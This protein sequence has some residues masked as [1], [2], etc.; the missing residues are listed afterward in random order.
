VVGEDQFGEVGCVVAPVPLPSSGNRGPVKPVALEFSA[1]LFRGNLREK[2]LESISLNIIDEAH[3]IRKL[4][5]S[6]SVVLG[7]LDYGQALLKSANVG[8]IVGEGVIGKAS[9]AGEILRE[10]FGD[11][12]LR[13]AKVGEA[14]AIRFA[15]ELVCPLHHALTFFQAL[16]FIESFSV[17]SGSSL[18]MITLDSAADRSPA[19]AFGFIVMFLRLGEMR[20]D[21]LQVSPMALFRM[22]SDQNGLTKRDHF[23]SLSG[24]EMSP[25]CNVCVLFGKLAKA[26]SFCCAF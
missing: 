12:F 19:K 20:I 17:A 6:G 9:S 7:V 5:F 22:V 4:L 11:C 26:R 2:D 13:E 15:D 8:R 18:K 14:F 3:A 1:D 21:A 23:K 24:G 16:D 10:K 25:G